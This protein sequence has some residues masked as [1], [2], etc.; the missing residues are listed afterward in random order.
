MLVVTCVGSRKGWS[1]FL[2]AYYV[3][4]DVSGIKGALEWERSFIN[5]QDLCQGDFF[6]CGH[7]D[8]RVL[9]FAIL[10]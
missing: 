6:K 5:L 2:S 8:T 7:Y 9:I 10:I 4:C 3:L 1:C